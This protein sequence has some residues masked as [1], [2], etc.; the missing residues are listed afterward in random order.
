MIESVPEKNLTAILLNKKIDL[1][2]INNV[3]YFINFETRSL[4]AINIIEPLTKTL[5]APLRIADNI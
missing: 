5:I 1:I 3:Y 2:I 4:L